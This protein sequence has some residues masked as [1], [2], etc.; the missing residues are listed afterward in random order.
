MQIKRIL[1]TREC[2]LGLDNWSQHD[3]KEMML[4][5]VRLHLE[6]N[7]LDA[8]ISGPGTLPLV[9]TEI[10][11]ESFTA[12]VMAE[13]VYKALQDMEF[14]ISSIVGF[15][16]DKG[17]NVKHILS[18]LVNDTEKTTPNFQIC[19]QVILDYSYVTCYRFDDLHCS[20][21]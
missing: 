2:V 3:G 18:I 7:E 1:A 13:F 10:E 11:S 9:F 14:P 17:S 20:V 6:P 4:I 21:M 8:K 16:S 5:S 12:Q 19:P 15:V